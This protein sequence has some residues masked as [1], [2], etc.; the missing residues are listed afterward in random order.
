MKTLISYIILLVVILLFT[1]TPKLPERLDFNISEEFLE[2][3][4][5]VQEKKDLCEN[6][7]RKVRLLQF[8]IKNN[9][10]IIE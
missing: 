9:L 8:E 1:K 4:K 2:I 5:E 6:L 3:S 10:G 7:K